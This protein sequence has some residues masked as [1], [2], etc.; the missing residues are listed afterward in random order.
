MFGSVLHDTASS[1]STLH[2]TLDRVGV[3]F[4]RVYIQVSFV[5]EFWWVFLRC[6]DD[7]QLTEYMY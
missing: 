2:S 7:V 3:V 1:L 6:G 5:F 4:K